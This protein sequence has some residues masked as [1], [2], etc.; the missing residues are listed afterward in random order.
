M[1][2]NIQKY[3]N[4]SLEK[5]SESAMQE[6]INLGGSGGL[7]A[8]NRSGEIVCPFSTDGLYRGWWR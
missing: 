3:K 2:L 5:A 1:N 4:Y 6:C 8:L 7:L